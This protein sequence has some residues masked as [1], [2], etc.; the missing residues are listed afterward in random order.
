[1]NYHTHSPVAK[2]IRDHFD[3]HVVRTVHIGIELL[4][5]CGTKQATLDP[6]PGVL[7]VMSN[8]LVIQKAALARMAF[9]R[10]DDSDTY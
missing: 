4:A 1:M 3:D 8:G 5:R 7:I 9:L 10:Q 6:F 2:G